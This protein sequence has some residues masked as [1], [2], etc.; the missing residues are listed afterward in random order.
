MPEYW[1]GYLFFLTNKRTIKRG[2][3]IWAEAYGLL[4]NIFIQGIR[5]LFEKDPDSPLGC[6]EMKGVQ[7]YVVLWSK[8]TCIWK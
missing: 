1:A 6:S 2:I 3:D 4:R 7:A 5:H 8:G